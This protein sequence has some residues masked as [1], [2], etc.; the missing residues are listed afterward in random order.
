MGSTSIV[1][2]RS[3]IPLN[4]TVP[5][6]VDNAAANNNQGFSAV[7]SSDNTGSQAF[8]P[9]S[10]GGAL[11]WNPAVSTASWNRIN[12]PY[13]VINRG[14]LYQCRGANSTNYHSGCQIQASPDN[15]T[16]WDI[17]CTI[18]DNQMQNTNVNTVNFPNNK[19][20]NAYRLFITSTVGTLANLGFFNL[21]YSGYVLF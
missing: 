14:F 10:T 7:S 5:I 20:Y 8:Q 16:T 18:P 1:I 15:G 11:Y 17:L 13:Q 2:N 19:I 3:D 6:L 21:Q 12:F 9:Y 4:T